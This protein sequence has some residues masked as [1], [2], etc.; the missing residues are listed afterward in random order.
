MTTFWAP[1]FLL[2]LVGFA[3][4]TIQLANSLRANTHFNTGPTVSL[5]MLLTGLLSRSLQNYKTFF[6]THKDVSERLKVFNPC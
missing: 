4:E 2:M 3:K 6:F 5:S 1:K